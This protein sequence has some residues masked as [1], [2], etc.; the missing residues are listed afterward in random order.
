MGRGE[1]EV[2]QVEVGGEEM[3]LDSTQE[4]DEYNNVKI[5]ISQK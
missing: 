2:D 3:E 5:I 1:K 4:K